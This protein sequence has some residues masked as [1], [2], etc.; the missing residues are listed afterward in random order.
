MNVCDTLA[1]LYSNYDASRLAER[2]AAAAK[3]ISKEQRRRVRRAGDHIPP[4]DIHDPEQGRVSSI[5]VLKKGPT[6]CELLSRAVV[7]LLSAGSARCR[8]DFTGHPQG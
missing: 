4:F 8:G 3:L 7:L 6:D 5:D 2:H 1:A